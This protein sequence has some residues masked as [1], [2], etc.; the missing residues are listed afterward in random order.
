MNWKPISEPPE[1]KATVKVLLNR[2]TNNLWTSIWSLGVEHATHWCE[3]P[4]P[5]PPKPERLPMEIAFRKWFKYQHYPYGDA[6]RIW[7]DAW[8]SATLHAKR[9]DEEKAKLLK[10][11]STMMLE[12]GNYL[13]RTS[14]RIDEALNGK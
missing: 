13:L 1:D 11:A 2:D 9:D 7:N 12:S 10:E 8:A 14:R 4:V 3:L 6:M 5:E